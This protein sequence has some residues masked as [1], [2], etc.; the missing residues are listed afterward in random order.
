[1]L[2]VTTNEERVSSVFVSECHLKE[3]KV[4]TR[5]RETEEPEFLAFKP[6]RNNESVSHG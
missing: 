5:G 3:S 6:K 2:Q 1:V 4:D